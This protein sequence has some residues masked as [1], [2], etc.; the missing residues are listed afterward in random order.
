MLHE[1]EI[2]TS[3]RALLKRK[4]LGKR[5]ASQI[6]AKLSSELLCDKRYSPMSEAQLKPVRVLCL[7]QYTPEF[8]PQLDH[9]LLSLTSA[10]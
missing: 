5:S 10:L 2:I 4:S 9:K 6:P 3:S 8:D 1:M 7:L